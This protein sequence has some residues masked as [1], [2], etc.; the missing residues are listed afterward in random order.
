MYHNAQ[1]KGER[2]SNHCEQDVKGEAQDRYFLLW[3]AVEKRGEER[4]AKMSRE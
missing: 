4:N 1:L 3:S 2:E